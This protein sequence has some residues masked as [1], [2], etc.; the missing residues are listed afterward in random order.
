MNLDTYAVMSGISV[1]AIAEAK[2]HVSFWKKA[3]TCLVFLLQIAIKPFTLFH[4]SVCDYK[5]FT[6]MFM[7]WDRGPLCRTNIQMCVYL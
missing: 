4:H 6:V 3:N 1:H 2:R 7:R 5:C